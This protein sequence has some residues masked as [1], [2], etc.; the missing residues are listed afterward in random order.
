MPQSSASVADALRG[1]N[2]RKTFLAS[3]AQLAAYFPEFDRC[4]AGQQLA[5][6][7]AL[8]RVSVVLTARYTERDF[9]QAGLELF[10]LGL[11]VVPG[12]GHQAALQASIDRCH[13]V[14]DPPATE[15]V[16]VVAAPRLA[17]NPF[18]P[19]A[20][21]PGAE[22]Q[23]LGASDPV[24]SFFVSEAL[25]DF[26]STSDGPPPASRE[27]RSNLGVTTVTQVGE[28]CAVCQETLPLRSKAQR[29]PCNHLFHYDCLLSWLERHN[30]CPLCRHRLPSER[31]SLD[32]V[33]EAVQR[34]PAESTGLYA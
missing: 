20:N 12:A 22:N 10:T 28:D 24:N 33:A 34:R 25:L 23:P 16:P 11:S 15:P 21:R 29:M 18:E 4:D 32:D 5:L 19:S 13:E 7:D 3:V 6:M 27:A 9:W 8:K 30:T 1:L 2:S 31:Q 26:L 17:F 14:L